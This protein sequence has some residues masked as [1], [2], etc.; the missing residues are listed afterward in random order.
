ME[1]VKPLTKEPTLSNM[2]SLAHREIIALAANDFDEYDELAGERRL[3][4]RTFVD[5]SQANHLIDE[6]GARRL[7]DQLRVCDAQ[8]GRD[9]TR[10]ADKLSDQIVDR[11]Q[12][13]SFPRLYL[14]APSRRG[15]GAEDSGLWS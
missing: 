8:I 10:L 12:R 3:L 15:P 7:L 9:L 4:G 1:L 13:Y 14:V 2:L 6:P 5:P 11:T